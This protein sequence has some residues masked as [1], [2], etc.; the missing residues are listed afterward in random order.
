MAAMSHARLTT[1][2]I[3]QHATVELRAWHNHF[4]D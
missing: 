4:A 3:A 2:G 1:E